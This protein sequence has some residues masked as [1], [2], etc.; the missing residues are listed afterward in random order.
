MDAVVFDFGGVLTVPVRTSTGQW[1]TEDGILAD[2]YAA[3]MREWLVGAAAAGSPIHRLETG[4]LSGPEFE[5]ALAA[6][7]ATSTG[8]PVRAEG[9]L[10]RMF[11]GM[12]VDEAMLAL[13]ADLRAAGLR[14]GVLSNSW[15]NEYPAD[16]LAAFDPVII[17]GD[18]GL[19]KP[20]PRIFQLVLDRLG[21]PADRVAFVDD[22]APNVAGAAELGIHAIEHVD[23][24]TTRAALSRLVPGLPAR[25]SVGEGA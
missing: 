2:S 15:G 24:A 25:A 12:V 21:L 16:V 18:V 10:T 11:A 17:S 22:V 8:V 13:A 3:V 23:A 20:D 7:L 14:V 19:R 6:R 4:E 9:L 1:L 5:R